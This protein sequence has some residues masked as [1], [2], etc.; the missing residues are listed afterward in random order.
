MYRGGPDRSG[1]GAPPPQATGDVPTDIRQGD[2]FSAPSP[3]DWGCTARALLEEAY[4]WPL[5]R[6]LGMYRTARRVPSGPGPPPQ[7]TGDVPSSSRA[8]S[9]LSP[10]PQATGD[11]PG[12]AWH[13]VATKAPS[14]GDWGCTGVGVA[15]DRARRPLP[16]RL[17]MYRASPSG[18]PWRPTPPQATGDVPR[19]ASPAGGAAGPSPGD[20]G[21]TGP[22]RESW[23]VAAPLP[24]RLGMYR[25]RGRGRCRR[26]PPPQATGDVPT[27]R[28]RRRS[29]PPPSPGDWGCTGHSA[30]AWLVPTPLPRRLGMYRWREP[31]SSG[32]TAPPQA[33][34]DVPR[35]PVADYR[36]ERPSPGDWGCTG[37]SPVTLRRETPLPRRLGIYRSSAR[38]ATGSSSPPQATGDVPMAPDRDRGAAT[39][40]PGDWGCTGARVTHPG[41]GRPLPRRLG[42]YRR[43]G[44]Q[45][46]D[47]LTPPQATGDVP[48]PA[49]PSPCPPTP[50]PGDWGCTA[51][52]GRV[53]VQLRPLPR[54][55]GMYREERARHH[56][57][58]PPPQATGDVPTSAAGRSSA[59][60]P[61]PG[62]WG[63]TGRRSSSDS[64]PLP[65]PRRLGM[66]RTRSSHSESRSTPP[67]AT[68][69]VPS[70]AGMVGSFAHPSPGDWGCTA[71]GGAQGERV[72]PL[73][74]RLGMY[75]GV[76]GHLP[77]PAAP[78]QATGDVPLVELPRWAL[79]FPSP[80]DWGCTDRRPLKNP[81]PVPLPRRLGMYRP[82]ACLMPSASAPPQATGDVP[83]SPASGS[84]LNTPS[85]GDW[86]CTGERE[87]EPK[88][89]HPLPRRLGM[90]R[91][92]SRS[93]WPSPPPPQATGDVPAS[94]AARARWTAPSPGDWGCTGRPRAFRVRGRPLPRRLG[95]YR[96]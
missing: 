19:A 28:G 40:S 46:R 47:G 61:S 1:A 26:R 63:C 45:A 11:V 6:R 57:R 13:G 94:D 72:G 85:P 80:G 10:P 68:G 5:P 91:A 14:P 82:P 22:A 78:P 43:H 15:R 77:R 48:R 30:A 16:R 23:E 8:L 49:R 39:P 4:P 69:D 84:C 31:S 75:R 93:R 7:A 89:D 32:R 34:G 60:S 37:A 87:R 73:P 62:D 50:S 41:R 79:A 66:Y 24:R 92:A 55:L 65:L 86:G 21:C 76:C 20:W 64:G 2:L 44:H 56:A 83:R 42:M 33:T 27:P 95:M 25:R 52:P 67:Q 90:Y 58:R 3:G 70:V 71:Q 38:R 36:T 29:P 74:R 54:R 35:R 53:Q 51:H 17:G 59:S 18:R 81:E 88:R 12:A 96:P 9:A